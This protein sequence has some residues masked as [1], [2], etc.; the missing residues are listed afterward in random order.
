M[1][2]AGSAIVKPREKGYWTRAWT[3]NASTTMRGQGRNFGSLRGLARSLA[4]G[5]DGRPGLHRQRAERR[6]LSALRKFSITQMSVLLGP[7]VPVVKAIL[8]PEG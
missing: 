3:L 8:R 1:R 4:R 7:V 5:A 2:A 6:Y